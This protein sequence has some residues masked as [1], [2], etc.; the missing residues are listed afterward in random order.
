MGTAAGLAGDRLVEPEGRVC[1]PPTGA[2]VPA[3]LREGLPWRG[4]VWRGATPPEHT[5]VGMLASPPAEGESVSLGGWG[6]G[7]RWHVSMSS[8]T[9]SLAQCAVTHG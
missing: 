1:P 4:S 9:A 7:M 2:V 6:S 3:A 8:C 5:R